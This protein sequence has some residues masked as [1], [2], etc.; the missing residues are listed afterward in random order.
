MTVL[1][2]Q[3]AIN[4]ERTY[5]LGLA[6]LA[7]HL[8]RR[9][10][11]VLGFDAR[12]QGRAALARLLRQRRDVQWIGVSL[13]STNLE[14]GLRLARLARRLASGARVVLGGPHP[15]LDPSSLAPQRCWDFL[16]RGDGEQP[17][18]HLVEGRLHPAVVSREQLAQTAGTIH[19]HQQLEELEFADRQV[20]AVDRYYGDIL[21]RDRRWSAMVV[22]RGCVKRCGYCAAS[23][24]SCGLHRRRPVA[25]VVEELQ[26]LQMDHQLCGVYLEDDNLLADRAGAEELLE[27]LQRHNP[28]LRIEL[29][30]GVDPM[31]LD[32]ALLRLMRA[33][34]ITALSLGIESTLR[35]NQLALK[36][37]VD[38]QHLRRVLDCARS[39][40]LRTTGFFIVGLPHDRPAAVLRGF[41]DIKLSRLDL[42]HLSVWR[43]L[44]GAALQHGPGG[45]FWRA[46]KGAFYLYF[47]ADPARLRAM[48]EQG[49][50]SAGFLL[51]MALRYI[52]W[53]RR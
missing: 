9:G 19:V 51:R 37:P 13:Y 33:A 36:R 30:N 3:P 32:P 49:E 10:H 31:L 21:K 29:P 18:A 14:A 47:Y 22:T 45:S 50:L 28:G 4:F 43:P 41:A 6:Y 12:L 52:R 24:L 39:L 2:L 25:S 11:Q 48:V 38:R 23:Q 35:E 5:P 44:P 40:G 27:A 1:L 17:L 53:L 46:L 42:A 15:T 8:R 16:V 26:R 20:F 34:G 7:G